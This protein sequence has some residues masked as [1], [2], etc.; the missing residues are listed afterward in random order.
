MKNFLIIIIV[1]TLVFQS[2][3]YNKL[4]LVERLTNVSCVP[5]ANINNSWY[6]ASTAGLL[7]S[8]SIS[9]IVYNVDWPSAT[10]P[11]HLL[12]QADNNTRRGYYGC[13]SV[14]W[15]EV[16]GST[17]TTTN[18]GTFEAAVTAGN[19]EFA[20]F[21]IILTPERF[22]NDV[23]NVHAK[24]IRDSSDV[25]T[26]VNTKLRVALTEKRVTFSSPPGSNGESVFFSVCRKMLP[27]G[28]GMEI[29]IPAAGDSIEYDFLY[30]PT[31][32]F[33]QSVN[34]DSIRVVAF[35]QNDDTKQTYQSANADLVSANR[36]NAAF[37]V[38]ETLGPLPYSVTFQDF[39]T[40]TDTTT[41]TSWEWDFDNDGT[42]DSQDPQPTWDFTNEQSYTV[43]LTVSDGNQ[44]YTRTLNNYITVIGTSSDILIVNGITY[45]NA[46]YIPEMEA[47]YNSSACFGNHQV[48][49][50]D[51]FGDQGFNYGANANIQQVHL[52][53]RTIPNSILNLYSKVIWIGNNFSGDNA[54]YSSTQVLDY[55]GQGGNFVLATRLGA[56]FLTSDLRTYCGISQMSGDQNVTELIALDDSLIN[57]TANAT[58][59]HSLI[60]FALL[61]PTSE[62]VPIF[63]DN[64][65]TNWT[66]GFRIQKSGDGAFIYIA[67]RPYRYDNTDSFHN[68]DYIIENWMGAGAVGI[69]NESSP[70]LLSDYQLF[71]NYPNPF[72]PSTK[73]SYLVK[74]SDNITLKVYDVL[75]REVTTLVDGFQKASLYTVNFDASKFSNGVYY[76]K[77][78]I[79]NEFEQTRKMLFLK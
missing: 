45:A 19:L 69:D 1:L 70:D 4:S 6:N 20:P 10:D 47:F 48:D 5:C 14:P 61:S 26:Y 76:Y 37:Q 66:A 2:N 71:Q 77:L 74:T 46:T 28:K 79:G 54:F 51:L 67:G 40:A 9:H 72:N 49:V 78:K 57:M 29:S 31:Q 50:W 56:T 36:V 33:S 17:A 41:I 12:N 32:A 58:P 68:Y 64:V 44:Q 27:N 23:I 65:A 16:N 53:D 11:M 3:A 42:I 62:S 25:G 39:S 52:F 24:I 75:G 22:S 59:A 8:N 55:V 21:K 63:D 30:I 15:M 73:I 43:S 34:F 18:Q 60:N 38:E 35:I 13:N 7:S